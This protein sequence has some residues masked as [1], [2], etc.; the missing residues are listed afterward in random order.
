MDTRRAQVDNLNTAFIERDILTL[1]QI[2]APLARGI[3]GAVQHP[4]ELVVQL[5]WWRDYY[6]FVR[7][8][9]YSGRSGATP[10]L[11]AHFVDGTP[12]N[13][14]VPS[15]AKETNARPPGVNTTCS[16]I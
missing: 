7:P 5:E 9:N 15:S 1:R 14:T 16:I 6:H 11:L 8:E 12:Q 10:H 3:A 2:V 13:L 4:A